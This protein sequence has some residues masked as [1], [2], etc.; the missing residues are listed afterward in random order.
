[1]KFTLKA[2]MDYCRH[3][4]VSLCFSP[5]GTPWLW[6]WDGGYPPNA[7]CTEDIPRGATV[8]VDDGYGADICEVRRK[9]KE[10]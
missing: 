3:E 2:R 7:V 4:P 6:R 9:R 8:V 10:E 1:M 5:V